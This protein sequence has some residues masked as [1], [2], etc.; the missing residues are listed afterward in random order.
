MITNEELKKIERKMLETRYSDAA[1]TREEAVRLINALIDSRNEF[2][3]LSG[4]PI[5][6]PPKTEKTEREP[7]GF[8]GVA[9]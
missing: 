9:C 2:A 6:F 3:A 1:I 4:H 7:V 5:P 8:N